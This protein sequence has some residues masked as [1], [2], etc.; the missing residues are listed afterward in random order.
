MRQC[1]AKNTPVPCTPSQA[2]VAKGR[3][4]VRDTRYASIFIMACVAIG[5]VVSASN[6]GVLRRRPD[7]RISERKFRFESMVIIVTISFDN[8]VMASVPSCGDFTSSFMFP[9]RN[10]AGNESYV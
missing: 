3:L 5:F 6:T 9:L 10:L 8:Y 4:L 7:S 2:V 1:R